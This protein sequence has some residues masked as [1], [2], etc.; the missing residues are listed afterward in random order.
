MWHDLFDAMRMSFYF[1]AGFVG[2]AEDEITVMVSSIA[3]KSILV[4]GIEIIATEGV[5]EEELLITAGIIA[6]M[7]DPDEDGIVDSHPAC[8]GMIDGRPILLV[9]SDNRRVRELLPSL[10]DTMIVVDLPTN[11]AMDS[12][13]TDQDASLVIQRVL[14]EEFMLDG[15]AHAWPEVF[16]REAGS[17]LA[18]AMDQA[19]GGHYLEV[20]NDYPDNAWFTC[21]EDGIDYS[22]LLS[23][24]F[25]W[26]V[27]T[28]LDGLSHCDP[29]INEFEWSVPSAEILLLQDSRISSLLLDQQYHIPGMLLDGNYL[30]SELVE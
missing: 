13:A 22:H 26:S 15:Y 23:R 12:S 16:G 3:H 28:M 19:R 25:Y 10:Q 8:R 5:S 11:A 27:M 4:Y 24:Y 1:V 18:V 29:T 2:Q 14:V 21:D 30:G 17:E 7:M 9:R 20:P 6:E